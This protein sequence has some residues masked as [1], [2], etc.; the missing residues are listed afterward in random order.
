MIIQP[1]RWIPQQQHDTAGQSWSDGFC[2]TDWCKAGRWVVRRDARQ[3]GLWLVAASVG[4]SARTIAA[5]V[6][7]C[8]LCGTNLSPHVEGVGE[9][10]GAAD[11]PL[12]TH[13]RRLAA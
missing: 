6:P 13:A 10:P 8:P 4:D 1:E 3:H 5:A 7:V 2:T 9:V 12:A 11:N